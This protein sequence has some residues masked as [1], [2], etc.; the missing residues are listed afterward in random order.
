[1][2]IV[3]RPRNSGTPPRVGALSALPVF[4]TLKNKNVLMVGASE[5][6]AWKAELLLATG[7]QVRVLLDGEAPCAELDALARTFARN[8]VLDAHTDW[9]H[10]ELKGYALCVADVA[11][12]E[13]ESFVARA[14]AAGLPTNVIDQPAH[15]DFQFGSIV[16]RSPFVIGISTSGAAPIL[17]QM[18]RQKIETLLPTHLGAWGKAAEAIRERTMVMLRP[19][20][21]RRS[22]WERFGQA[23]FANGATA[24][25]QTVAHE[26]LAATG[27]QSRAPQGRVT[28]VGAGPG[29]ADLLTL[30]AVRALQSADVILFDDLVSD[31][32]LELARREAKRMLV[33]KRGGRPSCK[34]HEI[35]DMMV[36]FAKAGKNVVRLKSGDPMI[37]GRA[38]EEIAMLQGHGISVDI[39]PGITSGLALAARLGTSLTHRDHG[40][41]LHFVTGHAKDGL[42]PKTI[43]WTSAAHGQDTTLF[44]MC[45]RTLPAIIDKLVGA[46]AALDVPAVIAANLHRNDERIWTGT[47]GEASNAVSLLSDGDVA[48]FAF[49]KGMQPTPFMQAP[50]GL[51]Q[52]NFERCAQAAQ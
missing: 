15:C 5:A 25:P 6:A 40:Q 37:F 7:A 11:P 24:N 31:E 23:A 12:D 33:G 30:K 44:Y 45:R 29:D 22:F 48:V 2:H 38:G 51:A 9:R 36:R 1:M 28:L 26:T 17:G 41:A 32:V 39:V 19:G 21:Q 4:F 35:N 20:A 42:L 14:R 46:G 27:G 50:A 47:L 34:Q 8:C 52:T 18:I 3:S 49:G 13:A 43:D 16:N 10:D